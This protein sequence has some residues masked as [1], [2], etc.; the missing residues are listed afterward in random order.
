MSISFEQRMHDVLAGARE[1]TWADWAL[2]AE[3]DPDAFFPPKGADTRAAKA[4][5]R[6]CPVQAECLDWALDHHEAF[7]IWGGFSVRERDI[8]RRAPERRAA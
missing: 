3:I 7:G 4:I 8:L 6:S 2:C 1:M 5:C